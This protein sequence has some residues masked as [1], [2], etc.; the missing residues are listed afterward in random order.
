MLAWRARLPHALLF[1]GP[2]GLGKV[3]LALAFAGA[4]L[5]ESP[6]P[7]GEACGRCLA[8]RWFAQ[9]N[10]PDL[11]L[12]LPEALRLKEE[13]EG[14]AAKEEKKGRAG[15]EITIDQ[16]RA[17]DDFLAVGTHRQGL[18][19]ILAHPAENLN[20]NAGNALLKMLEEPPPETLFLLV[21]HEAMRLLPTLR[22]R[23]QGVPVPLPLPEAGRAFLEAAGI[24]EA[25][26]WLA[27]AGG[28]PMLARD[29]ARRGAGWMDDLLQILAKGG[30]Q[31][32]LATAMQ[33]EK[34][35]KAVKGENPLPQ[36]VAWAQKWLV[37]LNLAARNLPI[38]FFLRH[39]ARIT[40]LAQESTPLRLSRFYRS[41][42]RLRRES[43]HPLNL[44]LFLEQFLFEYRALFVP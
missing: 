28:A 17:L 31:E 7:E 43:E 15:Q 16:V 39:R 18:R 34:T 8:C 11:R 4:L 19:I 35:L 33:L 44:R 41:L 14:K 10:H 27:L 3:E 26:S 38:R 6:T 12:L 1:S 29:L 13:D 22:S 40:T 32:V 9:G 37:D 24:G 36:L 25:E 42:L 20:R 23:C 5:C 30:R 21:A 2:R